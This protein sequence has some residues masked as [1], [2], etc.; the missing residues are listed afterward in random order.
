MRPY[1]FSNLCQSSGIC[2]NHLS[3]DSVEFPDIPNG[4]L[5]V[6]VP[7]TLGDIL[8][9]FCIKRDLHVNE[10]AEC[11]ANVRHLDEDL[12]PKFNQPASTDVPV[13]LGKLGIGVVDD[14]LSLEFRTVVVESVGDEDW[15]VVH[16][17]VSGGG[18]E[19]DPM[20]SPGD[21]NE[22]FDPGA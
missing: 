21:S 18:A 12:L 8:Q 10:V 17:R 2:I 9:K 6:D 3:S 20:V 16:P 4:S 11:L 14:V 7:S 1:E 15:N 19:E 5:L 13:D 22:S